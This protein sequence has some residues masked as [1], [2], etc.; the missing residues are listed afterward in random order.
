MIVGVGVSLIA[1]VIS[2][3]IGILSGYIGGRFDLVVQRFVDA[4]MAF[5]MLIIL[6]TM[7][8]VIGAGMWQIIFV[9]S[10]SFGIGGSRVLRGVV[11]SLKQ[12]VYIE[13]A[14]A[15]GASTRRILIRHILPNVMPYIII[16][17]SGRMA[18][19]IL[20]EAS[21]SFLGFG[22][23]PPEPSWGGMISGPGRAY[24]LQAP[25]LGV[26]PGLALSI[27]VYGV[28]MFGDAARDL[29]DPRMKGGLG[30][31]ARVAKKMK[32]LQVGSQER[33]SKA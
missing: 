8:A 15:M 28:N 29:L 10:F 32:E 23:P 14:K 26:W 16:G 18:G 12:E 22:I 33:G 19:V 20:T 13:A 9:L 6:M 11:I 31:Y 17:F 5:P 7:M 1:G 24:M 3:A 21:L 4:W 25:G 27:V 30:S 2:A